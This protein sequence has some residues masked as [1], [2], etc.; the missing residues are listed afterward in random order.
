MQC[1]SK[2][3][4]QHAIV[5]GETLLATCVDRVKLIKTFMGGPW[6]LWMSPFGMHAECHM[7]IIACYNH[8]L[9][10]PRRSCSR[11]HYCVL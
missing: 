9:V 5:H 7:P 10:A 8:T 3:Y 6:P 1:N 4:I 11:F 2:N